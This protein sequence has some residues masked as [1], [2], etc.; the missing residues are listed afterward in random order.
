VCLAQKG[1][2]GEKE[3]EAG[4]GG[5]RNGMSMDD[6]DFKTAEPEARGLYSFIK[7]DAEERDAAE[8]LIRPGDHFLLEPIFRRGTSWGRP[9]RAVAPPNASSTCA[10]CA[11]LLRVSF[12]FFFLWGGRTTGVE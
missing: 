6:E 8:E 3:M 4:E 10:H 11:N 9:R 2:D 7:E 12:S 5:R 1:W